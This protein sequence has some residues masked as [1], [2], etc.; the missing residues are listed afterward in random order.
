[1]GR[2][3]NANANSQMRR[4]KQRNRDVRRDE[5]GLYPIIKQTY[6]IPKSPTTGEQ[7]GESSC[8]SF[9]Q[10]QDYFGFTDAIVLPC[11][12]DFALECNNSQVPD[13]ICPWIH[14]YTVHTEDQNIRL[15]FEVEYPIWNRLLKRHGTSRPFQF[16]IDV[17]FG[18]TNN[19]QFPK[20]PLSISNTTT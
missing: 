17:S 10:N 6:Q 12:G 3:S 1:M 4:L 8:W 16:E 15:P 18:P 13:N 19:L 5:I 2:V 20:Y 14:F 11:P 9:S 7:G